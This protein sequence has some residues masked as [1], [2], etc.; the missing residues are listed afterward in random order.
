MN[1]E[2]QP[3]CFFNNCHNR[4]HVQIYGGR[5]FFDL[6]ISGRHASQARDL[7]PGQ[8]CVVGSYIDSDHVVFRWYSFS[9]EASMLDAD[10]RHRVFF[11]RFLASETLPKRKAARSVRHAALFKRTGDFKQGSVFQKDLRVADLPVGVR[12]GEMKRTSNARRA[13]GAGFG[14]PAENCLVEAAAMRAVV[15]WYKSRGWGIESVECDRCGFDL[16][17]SK[18][19]VIEEV[20]VKGVRGSEPSFIITAGEVQQAQVS[21]RFVLMVVTS[22]LSSSAIITSYS[23]A[24]FRR[25]FRLSAIQYLAALNS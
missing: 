3:V 24:E 18:G 15:A 19:S 10:R 13:V 2:M 1:R 12:Q 21:R 11:G 6:G 4:D 23:G 22:A 16:R 7:M 17:C 25:R 20:E 9:N 8:L 5:A 14:D